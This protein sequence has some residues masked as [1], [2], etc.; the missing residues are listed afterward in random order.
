MIETL[1]NRELIIAGLV[2]MTLLQ[3]IIIPLVRQIWQTETSS[4][5]KKMLEIEEIK[6]AI[7]ISEASN[8]R[9]EQRVQSVEHD[10]RIY[11]ENTHDEIKS[12]EKLVSAKLEGL[13]R[14]MNLVHQQINGMKNGTGDI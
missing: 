11:R 2:I 7:T 4:T 8:L 1:T 10:I 9:L 5:K 14:V 3:V 12:L 6:K 13:E